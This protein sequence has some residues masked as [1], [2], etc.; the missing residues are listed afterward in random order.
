[1]MRFVVLAL[2]TGCSI[3]ATTYL[4]EVDRLDAADTDVGDMS[5]TTLRQTSHEVIGAGQSLSCSS[6]GNT[7]AQTWSRV[8]GLA[9]AGI[10]GPLHVTAVTF[11]IESTTGS[12]VV[13][14]AI[15]RYTGPF[16]ASTLAG[17]T[18]RL[19]SA[20][21][22]VTPTS[23]AFHT[24][25]VDATVPANGFV[26]VSVA[27]PDIPGGTF[28]LGATEAAQS[29]RGYYQSPACSTTAATDTKLVG[30]AGSIIIDV[31]GVPE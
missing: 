2:I 31:S 30:A 19:N 10:A 15:D 11:A 22:E 12:P 24:V 13:D 29:H 14:V 8:F 7:F 26:A 5:P 6:G 21:T 17:A 23:Y 3:S 18:T 25:T 16:D 9:D 1:M 4:G 28:V 27:V 20:P